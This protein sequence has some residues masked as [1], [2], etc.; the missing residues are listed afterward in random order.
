M[1]LNEAGAPGQR[2]KSINGLVVV[3]VFTISAALLVTLLQP[4]VTSTEYVPAFVSATAAK[5]N[6]TLVSPASKTPSRRHA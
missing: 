4:P 1:V 5:F 3:D 6:A 2:I